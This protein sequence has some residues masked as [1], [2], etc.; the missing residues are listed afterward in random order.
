[1]AAIWTLR[2]RS[3]SGWVFAD[4][5]QAGVFSLFGHQPL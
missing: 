3:W 1:M 4:C 5:L 2:E